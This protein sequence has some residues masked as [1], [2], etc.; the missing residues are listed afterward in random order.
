VAHP[1]MFDD[2]DPYLAR[3]REIASTVP[4]SAEKI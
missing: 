4:G 1:Q 2:D 3:V